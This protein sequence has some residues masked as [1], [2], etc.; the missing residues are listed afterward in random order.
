[1]GC[2]RDEFLRWLP[3]ASRHAPIVTTGDV[4][5]VLSDHGTVEITITPLA[6]QIGRAHV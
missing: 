4:H 6:P 1:M 3:G 2:T 5:R